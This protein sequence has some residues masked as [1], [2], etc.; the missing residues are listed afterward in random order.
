MKLL[1]NVRMSSAGETMDG[2]SLAQWCFKLLMVICGSVLAAVG[3]ELFLIPNRMLVGGMTGLSALAAH[4]TEM[5]LGLFLFVLNLPLILLSYRKVRRNFAVLTVLGLLVFS[6]SALILH[7]VPAL[8]ENPMTA[9][10]CGG[11]ALGLG[12]GLVIRYGGTLDTLETRDHTEKLVKFGFKDQDFM[13][14]NCFILA[15]AGFIYGWEQAM[16]SILAYLL[17]YETVHF[18]LRGF[19]VHRRITIVSGHCAEIEKEMEARLG[20]KASVYHAENA[21]KREAA[22][23]KEMPGELHSNGLG[24]VAERFFSRR[25]GRVIANFQPVEPRR[26]VGEGAI[27]SGPGPDEDGLHKA[28]SA[29]YSHGKDRSLSY[30]IHFMEEARLKAIVK[31]IDPSAGIVTDSRGRRR[32]GSLA[33]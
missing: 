15:G 28:I 4:F 5:K 29:G 8:I 7:P 6:L 2:W 1:Q 25:S 11:T 23:K 27:G 18:S 12:I 26:F 33:E 19:S 24:R 13:L 20:R 21:E 10:F 14:L 17:A 32:D 30:T 3:L 22:A 16:Y 9:A 31:A